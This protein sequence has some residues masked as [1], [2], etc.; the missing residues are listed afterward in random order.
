MDI[1]KE[2]KRKQKIISIFFSV[3]ISITIIMLIASFFETTHKENKRESIRK[4]LYGAGQVALFKEI[5]AS[6]AANQEAPEEKIDELADLA[7]REILKKNYTKKMTGEIT[8]MV[9]EDICLAS[10]K[11]DIKDPKKLSRMGDQL[12]AI[13]EREI[14]IKIDRYMG[15]VGINELKKAT[16]GM[17]N[18][19][20]D[21]FYEN[22]PEERRADFTNMRDAVT[23]IFD[24]K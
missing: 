5:F 10:T 21:V 1:E 16:D 9:F 22:I 3:I 8:S 14:E 20:L 17:Y 13:A 2:V 15:L 11:W 12:M 23:S 19:R 7:V 18:E 6:L 24:V 4:T